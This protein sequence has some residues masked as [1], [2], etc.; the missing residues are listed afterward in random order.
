[1]E[2][3][4]IEDILDSK[5]ED[6]LISLFENQSR[7]GKDAL[8][9]KMEFAKWKGDDPYF[10]LA[11]NLKKCNDKEL[12][13]S[14]CR[15]YLT[16]TDRIEHLIS[17]MLNDKL[18]AELNYVQK[19]WLNEY[20]NDIAPKPMIEQRGIGIRG[21]ILVEDKDT[22]IKELHTKIDGKI[23]V[24][25][26]EILQKEIDKGFMLRPTYKEVADEFGNI[27]NRQGY[28]RAF[29]MFNRPKTQKFR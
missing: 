17:L 15:K 4:K 22:Y 29:N 24:A 28:N 21:K 8:L 14:K 2:D 6:I 27:G 11:Y 5:I 10:G 3:S 13:I 23:G 26:V 20:S 12:F 16:T 18:C 7:V 1:M 25:V 19:K 9:A